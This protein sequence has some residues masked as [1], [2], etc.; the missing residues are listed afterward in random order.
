MAGTED[1][2]SGRG[3]GRAAKVGR[4]PGAWARGV[5][6]RRAPRCGA[7]PPGGP[8]A[9]ARPPPRPPPT[10]APPRPPS[11]GSGRGFPVPAPP[12]PAGP[13]SPPVAGS[14]AAGSEEARAEGRGRRRPGGRHR[15]A[16]QDDRGEWG[17]AEGVAAGGRDAW[18]PGAVSGAGHPWGRGGGS[19][20][21]LGR[22]HSGGRASATLTFCARPS[23]VSPSPHRRCQAPRVPA[24]VTAR[25][26]P[27]GSFF[28]TCSCP[29]SRETCFLTSLPLLQLCLSRVL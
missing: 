15:A 21:P 9:A 4:D 14:A 13:P 29:S 18:L 26:S 22:C 11:P 10:S 6:G 28:F 3:R 25:R 2:Q 8:G 17:R 20:R 5:Q 23:P 24:A 12:A 7:G 19:S 27:R 1:G 16:G